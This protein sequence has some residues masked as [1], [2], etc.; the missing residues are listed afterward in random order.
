MTKTGTI[1]RLRNVTDYFSAMGPG[2]PVT[3]YEVMRDLGIGA[4][5]WKQAKAWVDAVIYIQGGKGIRRKFSKRGMVTQTRYYI[6]EL[7]N[8]TETKQDAG[9][10]DMAD[11]DS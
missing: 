6:G 10:K 5:Q 3:L 2:K 7:E 1:E 9:T 11:V 4:G 8:D